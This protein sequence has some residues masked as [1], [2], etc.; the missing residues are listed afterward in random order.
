MEMPPNK[1][2]AFQV[3]ADS[4]LELWRKYHQRQRSK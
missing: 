1:G 4:S 3:I 2:V